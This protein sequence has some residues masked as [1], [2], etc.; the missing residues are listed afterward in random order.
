MLS[1]E[2]VARSIYVRSK[3]SGPKISAGKRR[4]DAKIAACPCGADQE[5]ESDE[6][7]SFHSFFIVCNNELNIIVH[8][9]ETS[10]E[11]GQS[12]RGLAD[13]FEHAVRMKGLTYTRKDAG[14]VGIGPAASATPVDPRKW[15]NHRYSREY[16]HCSF[17]DPKVVL[18]A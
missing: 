6:K 1:L 10:A 4:E 9:D 16:E 15:S 14:V 3:R 11:S 7:N 18:D 13:D 8:R 5:R 17:S 12:W 2:K